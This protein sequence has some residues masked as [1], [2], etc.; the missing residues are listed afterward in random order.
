MSETPTLDV[1]LSFRVSRRA[2]AR[3][4]DLAARRGRTMSEELRAALAS[5]Q[6]DARQ[7]DRA[8]ARQTVEAGIG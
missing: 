5:H 7:G 1:R 8:Q 6:A 4:A 3:L 2:A